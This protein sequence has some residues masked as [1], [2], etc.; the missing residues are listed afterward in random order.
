MNKQRNKK[1]TIT[2]FF[3]T[4]FLSFLLWYI[5][6]PKIV[7]TSY[8]EAYF[9]AK[10]EI[11]RLLDQYRIVS[12]S[13]L[14]LPKENSIVPV[15]VG[16]YPIGQIIDHEGLPFTDNCNF[17]S[18][19]QPFQMPPIPASSTS[20]S[21]SLSGSLPVQF[22]GVLS[23]VNQLGL[24]IKA[25]NETTLQMKDFSMR[26][27]PRDKLIDKLSSEL[28][29]NSIESRK[30]MVVRGYLEASE[31]LTTQSNFSSDANIVTS[32]DGDFRVRY[33]GN[34]KF[35][36]KHLQVIPRFF[37]ISDI[38]VI[39]LG[40]ALPGKLNYIVD[41]APASLDARQKFLNSEIN[42]AKQSE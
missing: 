24:N 19:V 10:K 37:I 27:V 23:I 29:A 35:E 13:N 32:A 17:N 34:D 22:E 4:T 26:I 42:L 3:I 38:E 14:E 1:F 15:V 11:A 39:K 7:T 5:L 25:D 31:T 20:A 12:S 28:C 16:V 18:S 21:L 30:L 33:E 36:L 8:I 2:A 6:R 41:I 40:G 9:E